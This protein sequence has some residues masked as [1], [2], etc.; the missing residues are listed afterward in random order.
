MK[1]SDIIYLDNAATTRPI[2]ALE[3][4]MAEYR[5]GRWY[6]PSALY[7]GSAEA[8]AEMT[9]ARK[10]LLSAVNGYKRQVVFTASGTESNNMAVLD[11]VKPRRAGHFVFSAFEHSAVFACAGKLAESG[12]SVTFV[13]PNA[14]GIV[15]ADDIVDALRDETVLVSVMH[16]N[17][18]TGALND[19]DNIAARAKAANPNVRFHSD[20]VQA[21]LKVPY[22]LSDAVD[23]YATSAHKIGALKG[24]GA[25]FIKD[26]DSLKPLIY[27]GAQEKG[28]RAG[29]ENTFG[30]AAFSRAVAHFPEDD[31][32]IFKLHDRLCEGLSGLEDI[33]INSPLDDG[34]FSPY[35]VNTSVLGVR[36]ETLLHALEA[37][38]IYI[39]TG[40]A[41]SSKSRTNRVHDAL[42]LSPERGESAIR[43][44]FSHEN[45]MLDVDRLLEAIATEARF[46]RMFTRR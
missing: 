16:V 27:G 15:S 33:V 31:G 37:K 23:S 36:S 40:S 38:G 11:A 39:G 7:K 35:I 1:N 14:Q 25:L 19:I 17:N 3:S 30:I 29:T 6:N 28:M 26:N 13:P 2:E 8:E 24:T 22:S 44:S 4:L 34:R 9:E 12:H 21:F 32:H 45:T 18:E 41:C 10:T 5:Q 42:A 20:G 43:I 46:L